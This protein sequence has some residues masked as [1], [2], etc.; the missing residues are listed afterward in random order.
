MVGGGS[1]G[2]GVQVVRRS[3]GTGWSESVFERGRV[4]WLKVW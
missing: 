2:A 4:N 3:Q 1:G